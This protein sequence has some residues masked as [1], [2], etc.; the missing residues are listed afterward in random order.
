MVSIMGMLQ[1]AWKCGTCSLWEVLALPPRKQLTKH[2]SRSLK[3]I[4]V[5]GNTVTNAEEMHRVGGVQPLDYMPL[6]QESVC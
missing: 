2:F 4:D 1:Y 3:R 6:S 5:A